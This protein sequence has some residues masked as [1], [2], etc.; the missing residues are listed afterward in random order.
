MRGPGPG[1]NHSLSRLSYAGREFLAAR[2]NGTPRDRNTFNNFCEALGVEQRLVQV[3]VR[4]GN[5]TAYLIQE[6][7][8]RPEATFDRLERA[9]TNIGQSDLFEQLQAVDSRQM[10][11][12]DD[13]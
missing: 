10:Y 13:V 1:P 6:Y 3:S 12:E 5:P 9:L 8:E 4:S 11:G 2:L 7:S